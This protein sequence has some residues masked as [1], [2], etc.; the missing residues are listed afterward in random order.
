MAAHPKAIRCSTRAAR[1]VYEAALAHGAPEHAIQWVENPSREGTSYL[2]GHPGVALVL[3]TGATRGLEIG[4]SYGYS[5]LWIGAAIQTNGGTLITIEKERRK[6]DI[7]A[8]HFVDAGLDEVIHC[9]TG[10]ALEVIAGLDGP[11]DF[12]FS[13]ADKENCIRYMEAIA[14]KLSPGAMVVTDNTTGCESASCSYELVLC[15]LPPCTIE[16]PDS[17]CVGEPLTLCGPGGN[18]GYKWTLPDGSIL[19]PTDPCVEIPVPDPGIYTLKVQIED[20]VADRTVD[21]TEA[22]TVLQDGEIR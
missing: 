1:I 10:I 8:G 19:R 13:D 6:S 3:A 11:F 14:P 2:M 17:L 5:G 9:K 7:A 15:E 4:T 20:L 12:V 21:R 18:Y 22:F 16:G